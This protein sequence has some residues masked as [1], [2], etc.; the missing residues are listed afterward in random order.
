MAEV[1]TDQT[2]MLKENTDSAIPGK[3]VTKRNGIDED[4]SK[5][6]SLEEKSVP[7]NGVTDDLSNGQTEEVM[8]VDGDKEEKS[9][10]NGNEKKSENDNTP[11]ILSD[12]GDSDVMESNKGSESPVV[13][14][15]DA[16]Q[17][18]DNSVECMDVDGKEDD[19][20]NIVELSSNVSA[21]NSDIVEVGQNDS[22]NPSL[23][24]EDSS[25]DSSVSEESVKSGNSVD[26]KQKEGLVETVKVDD[27]E[28]LI[29]LN[30]E[31]E[32]SKEK[33]IDKKAE[34]LSGE[35]NKDVEKQESENK[36]E[37]TERNK[38]V[39][40]SDEDTS[41][42]LVKSVPVAA[43]T[44]GASLIIQTSASQV[45]N[46][47]NIIV[48]GPNIPVGSQL[49]RQGNQFGYVTLVGKQHIFVPVNSTVPAMVAK[50]PNL[51]NQLAPVQQLQ[52][53]A[54]PGPTL[55]PE[56]LKPKSSW[57]MIELMRWELQN[58]VPDNYNWSVVFHG[59]KDDLSSVST[60][61]QELGS[62]VVKEQVYKDIIQIQTK[63]KVAGD[64]KDP[65]IES[66]E[67]MKTVYENTKKKVEHLQLETKECEE[68]K[69]KTESN[70]VMNYHKDFPHYDPPWDTNRGWLMCAHCDFKTRTVAHF[71][72]HTKDI[73]NVQAK[74]IE[75][76]HC[77]QCSLCP[78]NTSTK[79]KLEKHQQKC[80]KH[81]KLN[82]NLQPLYHDVNFCMKTCFYKPKKV[83]PK[84]PPPV[85]PAA[86]AAKPTMLTRQQGAPPAVAQSLLPQNKNIQQITPA[87][88]PNTNV[89]IR[90]RLPLMRSPALQQ[91]VQRPQ[92]QQ[93]RPTLRP[94][95][96][97][98]APVPQQKPVKPPNKEMSGFEVCELCGGYVK[99]RQALRIHFYY[100]HKVEMPQAIFS[101]PNPPL[102]C[103][104][105]KSHY[106]TT[107]GLSKHKTAQR[108]FIGAQ[109][110]APS[111]KITTEMECFMCVKRFPNMFL[112]FEKTHGMT[113]KDLVLVRKCIM[114]GYAASDYKNLETHL[115][116][117][118]GILIKVNDYINDKSKPARP[119]PST[120]VIGGGKNVGKI[121][122]CVFC[123][124]QFPD[125][126]QLT[127]HCI[128]IHATC[129][130]CGMVVA[131]SKHLADH[132]CRKAH[133][134]RSCYI[135]GT[136]VTSQE[137]YAIHL[138]SHVKP[139]RVKIENLS[140]DEIVELKE[141]IKREYK[142]AVISLDSEE[143]SD[144]EVV[145]T[146]PS[147]MKVV[148]EKDGDDDVEMV[149]LSEDT[150]EKS[151]K[152]SKS[153]NVTD[154]SENKKETNTSQETAKISEE[155]KTEIKTE[156]GESS[157][158]KE[159]G[160]KSETK[161]EEINIESV[162]IKEESVKDKTANISDENK[163]EIKTE[164]GESSD[165]KET[166][167]KSETKEKEG[168]IESVQ[169][170]E[171]PVK[172]KTN[173]SEIADTV[174]K[175]KCETEINSASKAKDN[176]K[177]ED[178]T[179]QSESAVDGHVS[180]VKEDM[181]LESEKI[182]NDVK[183]ETNTIESEAEMEERLLGKED[184]DDSVSNSD[185]HKRKKSE[186][187]I[188]E[189]ELLRDDDSG[190][191][192]LKVE[193]DNTVKSE[194]DNAV[195]SAESNGDKIKTKPKDTEE[196]SYDDVEMS[197]SVPEATTDTI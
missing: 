99:D 8:E 127:M 29:T 195:T 34:N 63:K 30:D 101:R 68:C 109:P 129:R 185:S 139:C 90:Q 196:Q 41:A 45:I 107:Q 10:E 193:G 14:N 146:K 64:L 197:E 36:A 137:K 103:E 88:R 13:V 69:F 125:N 147:K 93:P 15:S 5:E 110:Q 115:V 78:L 191:K 22:N 26:L 168:N 145:E 170:N 142:P 176:S 144:V 159:T 57:E 9:I 166:G 183:V 27:D 91:P 94:P 21:P 28:I 132:S 66:L 128:K 95:T 24:S 81:F 73:H 134:N 112:H 149:D 151:D 160:E 163:I 123:Q 150:D 43:I 130:T 38:E 136:I 11:V 105:C 100:A 82:S 135:C 60:F 126:I 37:I 173:S 62:D 50:N 74:F 111:G 188:D 40:S 35:N 18:D 1:T 175:I 113:M 165:M 116:N 174:E 118:H 96:L 104:V 16:S 120:A 67:K 184:D 44:T 133:I 85:K 48:Q 56:D 157:D 33:T 138:R 161:E 71:I 32:A 70:V 20:S 39:K 122:Y 124:I 190:V 51:A 3:L 86:A 65:E 141:K 25:R 182:S 143:D 131:T 7:V 108:H 58:R 80:I 54:A 140:T 180:K 177:S 55:K 79:N 53:K 114:C 23:I 47:Q 77:F 171:E 59:R 181:E 12:N 179:S 158:V 52:Q 97:Q 152:T 164:P 178:T 117:T 2:E 6:S 98:R 84:P 42:N 189:D 186:S 75:K 167:E 102:T 148:L 46:T 194:N 156:S 87:V 89:A 106:W 17:D 76:D 4:V 83:V 172:D 155:N 153:E 19:D 92:I 61:L 119:T 169:I 162:Q 192:R 121:N 31:E 72:F 187:D 154:E 49:I